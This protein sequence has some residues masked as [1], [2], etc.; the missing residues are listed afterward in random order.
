LPDPDHRYNFLCPNC[1][2]NFSI[3]LDRIPPV[4]ARFRCPHCKQPMDF[5][6]R[7]EARELI[8]RQAMGGKEVVAGAAPASKGPA[9]VT[10]AAPPVSS[11]ST[12][13]AEGVRFRVDKPGFQADIFDRR[14]IRNLIR[15]G[16]VVENDRLRV[17]DSG[18]V[19][20]GSLTYLKSL[21]SLAKGQ[22]G[23]P[24]PC[25]RTHTDRVAFFRC[26][27]SG[28]PLCEQCAPE[29]K[30]GGTTIRV[31]QHCGGTATDL[32]PA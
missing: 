19:S 18:P 9:N 21:F 28:R 24:P 8:G 5:P 7:D 3:Q 1:S 29:K 23:Q 6:S 30:F 17:D 27:D 20:A 15:T 16:E 10:S 12:S 31:C 22:R 25:C 14:G 32:H 4:Q 2:G 13:P 26:H 11:G